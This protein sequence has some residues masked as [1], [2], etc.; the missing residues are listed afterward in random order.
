MIDTPLLLAWGAS[1]KV[2]EKGE[3]IFYEGNMSKSYFQILSGAVKMVSLN[4]EGKEFIQGVFK[5]GE[6]FGE[7]PLFIDLPYPASAR[8]TRH[9]ELIRL[10]KE[11]FFQLLEAHRSIEKD[12]LKLL[13]QRIF[14][15]SKKNS[16]NINHNP[17]H[18]IIAFLEEYK[19]HTD[20]LPSLRVIIPYTRQEI[21]DSTGLRVETVIRTLSALK[22]KQK[23]EIINRKLYY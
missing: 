6:S 14:Y 11:V 21:A 8:A 1:I 15:K 19:T 5:D 18:R 4:E 22:Q 3:F 23:V 13:A 10:P 17:E 9:T 20:T 2:F 16:E 7:P 12:F